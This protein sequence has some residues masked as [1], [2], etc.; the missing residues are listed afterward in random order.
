[1]NHEY[2]MQLALKEA[3]KAYEA[4]EVPIGA[5]IVINDKIF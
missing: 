1:M 4:G 3:A 2:Y 5:I